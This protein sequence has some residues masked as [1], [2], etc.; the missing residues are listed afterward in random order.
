MLRE[1]NMFFLRYDINEVE[2]VMPE[3]ANAYVLMSPNTRGDRITVQ[4]YKAT[5]EMGRKLIPE[6]ELA[7]DP[8][9]VIAAIKEAA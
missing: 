4:F 8:I 3:G 1:D 9:R 2:A 6:K 7:C 5:L